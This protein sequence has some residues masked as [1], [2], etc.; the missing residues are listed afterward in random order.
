MCQ[1]TDFAAALHHLDIQFS[2]SPLAWRKL[3]PVSN[4]AELIPVL[5]TAI[6]PI[7]LVSGV[8]LLLLTMTNRLGRVIDRARHLS[9]AL[10]AANEEARLTIRAQLRILLRRARLIRLAITLA[11]MSALAA[12]VLIIMLFVTAVF[13]LENALLIGL[14][15]IICMVCLIGSLA[16]F[17][18][19]LN[20]SLAALKLE[21]KI[22]GSEGI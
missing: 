9:S 10:S 8:G 14:L 22:S 20:Q 15:F 11:S 3:M 2:A 18:I 7:I 4:V 13:R 17:I 6:G 21:L 16:V 12:A 19:D 5:Q 1:I